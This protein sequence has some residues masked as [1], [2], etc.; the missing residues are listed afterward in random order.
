[1]PGIDVHV[2][3]AVEDDVTAD[4]RQIDRQGDGSIICALFVRADDLEEYTTKINKYYIIGKLFVSLEIQMSQ[5]EYST[6]TVVLAWSSS[7]EHSN[8]NSDKINSYVRL[9]VSE[10]VLFLLRMLLCYTNNTKR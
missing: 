6:D 5:S 3:V 1:M 8:E 2:E 7:K 4:D 9:Q 10:F